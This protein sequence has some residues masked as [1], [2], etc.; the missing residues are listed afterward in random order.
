MACGSK[1]QRSDG[2]IKSEGPVSRASRI[3]VRR[4]RND[5]LSGLRRNRSA[6]PCHGDPRHLLLPTESDCSDARALGASCPPSM[7]VP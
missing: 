3:P 6:G 2:E 7:R 5:L 1:L 4:F